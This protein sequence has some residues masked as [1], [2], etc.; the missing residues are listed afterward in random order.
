MSSARSL[1]MRRQMRAFLL[2]SISVGHRSVSRAVRDHMRE[3]LADGMRSG[4]LSLRRAAGNNPDRRQLA[5]HFLDSLGGQHSIRLLLGGLLADLH[6][7]HY[8]W[9]ATGDLANSDGTT[10][11]ERSASFVNCLDVLFLE[12][13]IF[14]LPNTC[15]G[16]ALEFLKKTRFYHHGT[17]HR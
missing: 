12:G 16:V 4:L 3:S 17:G 2:C 8:S 6:A 13:H 7:E 5:A 15:T 11:M 1:A 14:K 10:V 9:V